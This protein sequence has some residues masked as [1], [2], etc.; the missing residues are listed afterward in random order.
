VLNSS[1]NVAQFRDGRAADLKAQAGGPIANPGEMAFSHALALDVLASIPDCQ[2]ELKQVF[3]KDIDR[4]SFKVPTLCNVEPTDPHFHDGA[5]NTLTQVVDVM[6]QLQLGRKYSSD[7]NTRIV[8]FLKTLTGAQ[9]SFMMPILPPSSDK[10]PR[11]TP[12][13]FQLFVRRGL[14]KELPID[15]AATV[16]DPNVQPHHHF[17]DVETG[18]VADI[19]QGSLQ[20]L[21][22]PEAL[23]GLRLDGVD[24]II[25]VRG[26]DDRLAAGTMA[27][28]A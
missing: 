2:R 14:L 27:T 12:F 6:G 20:V 18:S 17:C 28:A 11:P 5:V 22:L 7:E 23:Q 21:G 24:V 15:G 19:P 26:L 3:G 13:E 25:R 4:F 9:P 10:T 8:A 1:L 16:Y